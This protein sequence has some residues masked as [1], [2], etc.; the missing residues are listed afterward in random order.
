M[1]G[2]FEIVTVGAD[3]VDEER[4]FCYKSKPKSG[5]YRRKLAWL[6]ERFAEGMRIKIVYEGERSVG[7]IEYIPG[8]YAWRAVEAAGYMVV[9]CLWVVG[10]GKKKGHGSRLLEVCVQDARERGMAGVAMVTSS[11]NWL[12]GKKLLLKNDFEVVDQTPP[13]FDLLVKRFGDAPLPAF[14]TNWEDRLGRYGP[15]LTV[16]RTDQ[17]PYIELATQKVMDAAGGMGLESRVVELGS[18][19]EVQASAPSPY[20]VFNV[21]YDGELVAYHWIGEKELRRF[22]DGRLGKDGAE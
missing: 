14:P 10:K 9:H 3:N 7:F 18:C 21:V 13:T 15:D 19:R 16:F 17:C 12:A 6:R 2:D 4:F 8:E 11:G 20:G 5:G 1:N 22:F